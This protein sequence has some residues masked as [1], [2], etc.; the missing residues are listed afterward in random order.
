MT[1]WDEPLTDAEHAEA[2]ANQAKLRAAYAKDPAGTMAA[3]KAA[4]KDLQNE[5]GIAPIKGKLP[6]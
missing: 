5:R 6:K 4:V 3:M 1:N 2:V